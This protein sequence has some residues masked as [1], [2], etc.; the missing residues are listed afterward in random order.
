LLTRA[1]LS[2]LCTA[3]SPAVRNGDIYLSKVRSAW[4]A[5]DGPD[6]QKG[7]RRGKQRE[8]E[9]EREHVIRLNY[10]IGNTIL[11]R[12][13]RVNQG[14]TSAYG[15]EA[16]ESEARNGDLWIVKSI[17]ADCRLFPRSLTVGVR[18][19]GIKLHGIPDWHT[20]CTQ[21]A[22]RLIRICC[23]DSRS[24]LIRMDIVYLKRR[25]RLPVDTSI[26]R[27]ETSAKNE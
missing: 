7:R 8:K 24:G 25:S 17:R 14:C 22:I 13:T 20:A 23:F 6:G 1:V 15:K 12:Q 3:P 19:T 16:T 11:K 4:R 18:S 21:R 9:R 27:W 5:E 26:S 10:P 2:R